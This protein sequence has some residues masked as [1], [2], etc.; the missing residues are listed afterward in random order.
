VDS[1]TR[2]ERTGMNFSY[3]VFLMDVNLSDVYNWQ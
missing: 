3:V 2:E 1:P